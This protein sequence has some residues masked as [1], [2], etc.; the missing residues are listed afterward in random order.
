VLTA[1]PALAAP[2][3]HHHPGV[4]CHRSDRHDQPAWAWRSSCKGNDAVSLPRT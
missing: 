4:I 2:D 3:P 1:A